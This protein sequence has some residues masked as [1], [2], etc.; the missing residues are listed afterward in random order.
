VRSTAA[1]TAAA[2]WFRKY[3]EQGVF[4][5]LAAKI[6]PNFLLAL[7]CRPG[8]QPD[9]KNFFRVGIRISLLLR[10]KYDKYGNCESE[11]GPT[12]NRRHLKN[13]EKL[14]EKTKQL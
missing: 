4:R 9:W 2:R 7:R 8:V 10:R 14:I 12:K 13:P 1:T 11:T 6:S 5:N 3:G